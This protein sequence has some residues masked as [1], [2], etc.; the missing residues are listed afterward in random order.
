[1]NELSDRAVFK[2]IHELL[3]NELDIIIV[4]DVINLQYQYQCYHWINI[5]LHKSQI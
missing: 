4:S 5:I 3:T 2:K 1:M